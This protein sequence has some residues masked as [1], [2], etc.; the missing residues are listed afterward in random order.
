[1]GTLY[2]VRIK[3]QSRSKDGL[4]EN[5]AI[6]MTFDYLIKLRKIGNGIKQYEM[7]LKCL[8]VF[9]FEGCSTERDEKPTK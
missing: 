7:D 1:M 5:Q 2:L 8:I 4:A 3:R 9:P 6:I